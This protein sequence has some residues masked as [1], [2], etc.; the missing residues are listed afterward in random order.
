MHPSSDVISSAVY[1]SYSY[2][3]TSPITCDLPPSPDINTYTD[4]DRGPNQKK[5]STLRRSLEERHG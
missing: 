3:R 2:A 5:P 4:T 1:M